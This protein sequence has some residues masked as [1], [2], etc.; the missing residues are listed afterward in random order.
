MA[1]LQNINR[2][3][4]FLRCTL[5]LTVFTKRS[6]CMFHL[7]RLKKF[8][9]FWHNAVPAY[10]DIVRLVWCPVMVAHIGGETKLTNSHWAVLSCDYNWQL[11]SQFHFIC[12][13]PTLGHP[14]SQTDRRT[15]VNYTRH[16]TVSLGQ[17]AFLLQVMWAVYIDL[18]CLLNDEENVNGIRG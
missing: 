2:Y 12:I 18:F 10:G 13:P 7:Q 4:V 5:D 9:N 6:P 15:N 3:G 14:H 1:T 16:C 17:Q 8:V 11:L